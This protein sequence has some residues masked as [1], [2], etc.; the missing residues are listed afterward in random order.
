M[1]VVEVAVVEEEELF[2]LKLVDIL[3]GGLVVRSLAKTADVRVG[4]NR[5]SFEG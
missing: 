3:A 5:S 4:L 1:V 2:V